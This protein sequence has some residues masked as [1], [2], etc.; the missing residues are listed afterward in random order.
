MFAGLPK[1]LARWYVC[2]ISLFCRPI[3]LI[4]L[5]A[6]RYDWNAVDWT[7]ATM[8]E[9]QTRCSPSLQSITS[10]NMSLFGMCHFSIKTQLISRLTFHFF[11]KKLKTNCYTQTLHLLKTDSYGGG[12][13]SMVRYITHLYCL[14]IQAGFYS[15]AVLSVGFL[16]E[17]SRVRSSAEAKGFLELFLSVTSG[18]QRK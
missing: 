13:C 11:F 17:G 7:K 15:E 10:M 2:F 1:Y 16:C 12:I 9:R 14:A 8:I 18:A 6:V 5:Q 3:Y 4:L